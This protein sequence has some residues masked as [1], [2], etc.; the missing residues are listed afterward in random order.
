MTP[1]I[2]PSG[3]RRDPENLLPLKPDVFLILT[4]LAD[5]DRHGYRIMQDA[6]R[7]TGGGMEIQAGA[8][9]RRLKWMMEEGLIQEVGG[10]LEKSGSGDRRRNYRV[11]PF[12][13]LAAVEES[14]RM[15]RLL[16]SARAA[17]LIPGTEGA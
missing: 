10:D 6:G 15:G 2:C 5:G 9:Y 11:T 4:I 3:T 8:L 14:R 16:A 1:S 7:W 13:R 17:D 12:G